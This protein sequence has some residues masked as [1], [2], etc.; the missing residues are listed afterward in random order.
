MRR[1]SAANLG[2]LA[3]HHALQHTG[4]GEAEG[5]GDGGGAGFEVW[6]GGGVCGEEGGEGRGERVQVVAYFV[7]GAFYPTM[8]AS[9]F[10]SG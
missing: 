9:N 8:S 3:D 1:H 4:V 2:L 7:D 10:V 6:D 5:S